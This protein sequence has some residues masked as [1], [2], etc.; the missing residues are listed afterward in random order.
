M[1]AA[2]NDAKNINLP[3]LPAF[4]MVELPIKAAPDNPDG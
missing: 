2:T 4:F 3:I 1:A